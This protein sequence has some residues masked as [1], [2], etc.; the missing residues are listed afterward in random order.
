[1][2]RAFSKISLTISDAIPFAVSGLLSVRVSVEN[3]ISPI[4]LP[5]KVRLE[6]CL[7]VEYVTY[8]TFWL[9]RNQY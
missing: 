5:K 2:S 4:P 7:G 1:M 8:Q 6:I 3:L 9:D